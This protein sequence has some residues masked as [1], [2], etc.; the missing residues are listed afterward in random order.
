MT[1]FTNRTFDEISIGEA[2]RISHRLT[3]AD[4]E[5]LA[6][7]SGD[8]G[9][10]IIDHADVR[11]NAITAEAVAA[12]ALLSGLLQRRLL[13]PGTTI[14]HQDLRFSGLLS[15]G[16]EIDGSVAAK[17]KRTQGSEIVFECRVQRGDDVLVGGT[18]TVAAP[19]ARLRYDDVTP[20][21]VVLRRS[22]MFARLIRR[23]EGVAPVVC[24]VVHPC[25]QD[26]L[27][28][29]PGKPSR[30]RGPGKSRR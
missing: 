8:V 23:C 26:S 5:A 29:P 11:G 25:D 4:V 2:V 9:L 1:S 17:E 7:V 10:F 21:N 20:P 12:E 22:D 14:L 6:F 3:T 15:V 27:L 13:G 30:W 24:A 16:D 28:G 18:V 19:T